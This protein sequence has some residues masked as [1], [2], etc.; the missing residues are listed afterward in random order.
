MIRRSPRDV[1]WPGRSEVIVCVSVREASTAH[2]C[3]KSGSQ[4]AAAIYFTSGATGLPKMVEHSHSSL[5]IKA[6]MEAG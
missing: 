6:K 5:G 1:R 2:R 4:E 3:V